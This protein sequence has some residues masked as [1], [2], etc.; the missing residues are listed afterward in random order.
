VRKALDMS[1]DKQ[2]IAEW[3]QVKPLS[4]ITPDGIFPGYLPPKGN[5]FDPEQAKQLLKDY[6]KPVQF[7]FIVTA[8]P[9]GRNAGQVLQQFWKKIGADAEI[10]QVEQAT[11]PVRAFARQ[12]QMTPWRIIDFPDPEPI[13]YSLF[14]TGSPVALANY[15]NPELDVL[16]ERARSTADRAKRTEDYC[17]I[18]RIIN[19]E[20][21][22]F[23]TFQITYY[24]VS[25]NKLKGLPPLFSGVIDV[26]DTW[27]E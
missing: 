27:L 13:M 9:R 3:R 21:T 14:H 2:A 7:K 4:A 12:Y 22:W 15:S 25:N 16:L 10:E 17:A 24:A 6:G 23:F 8:T 1:L 11:I 18:A 19:R 26:S 20:A 5:R